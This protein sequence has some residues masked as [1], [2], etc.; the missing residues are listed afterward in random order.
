ME[1][2]VNAE[3][4]AL[5]Q[6]IEESMKAEQNKTGESSKSNKGKDKEE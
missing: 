2:S 4:R 5:R 3:E 6:A 1:E